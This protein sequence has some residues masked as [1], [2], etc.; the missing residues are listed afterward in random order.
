MLVKSV[1]GHGHSQVTAF[2]QFAKHQLNWSS[3]TISTLAD[4]M[5]DWRFQRLITPVRVR[6]PRMDWNDQ[7]TDPSKP[8]NGGSGPV[9][10]FGHW[11][12]RVAPLPHPIQVRVRFLPSS[13]CLRAKSQSGGLW[14]WRSDHRLD[15]RNGYSR[16]TNWTG[17]LKQLATHHRPRRAARPWDRFE[18]EKGRSNVKPVSGECQHSQKQQKSSW[19]RAAVCSWYCTLLCETWGEMEGTAV[20]S[21]CAPKD[22]E[23]EKIL[24]KGVIG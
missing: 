18:D 17:R 14:P 6:R 5:H 16:K 1:R 22:P 9:A 12:V 2:Y 10:A 11:T 23:L 8:V 19:V 15:H 3:F 13:G 24:N 7:W 4:Q 21:K 20:T